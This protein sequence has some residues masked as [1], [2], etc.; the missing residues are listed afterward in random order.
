[1]YILC[2]DPHELRSIVHWKKRLQ[3]ILDFRRRIAIR[4]FR[5]KSVVMDL[6]SVT[7]IFFL[8][9]THP[10]N[11]KTFTLRIATNLRIRVRP[12]QDQQPRHHP[13]VQKIRLH[14]RR[15]L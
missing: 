7:T 13:L 2:V 11:N 8:L 15:R 3:L 10:R 1:M 4:F 14:L 12:C 5:Q 9:H 6:H